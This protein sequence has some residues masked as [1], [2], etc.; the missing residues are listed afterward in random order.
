LN[1]SFPQGHREWNVFFNNAATSDDTGVAVAICVAA[2]SLT[3]YSVQTGTM[4]YLPEAPASQA[5]VTCPAGTVD[6]GGGW[7]IATISDVSNNDGSTAS[8]PYGTN[9]WRAFPENQEPI[10]AYGE[11]LVVCAAQPTNWAQVYSSYVANPANTASTVTVACPTGTKVLGGG[12]FNS[13]SDV[14]VNIGLT[15]SLS[16]LKGWS[17]TENNDSSSSESVDAWAVCAKASSS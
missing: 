14:S 6:L 12:G 8:A 7:D 3:D 16:N 1:S 15:S 4:V 17:I 10:Y 2:S 13:S 9:G 5:T 11:A